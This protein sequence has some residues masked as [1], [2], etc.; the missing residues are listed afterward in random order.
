L[1]LDQAEFDPLAAQQND[2]VGSNVEA[3]G[4]SADVNFHLTADGVDAVNDSVNLFACS[5]GVQS[6]HRTL[7]SAVT[8]LA[9]EW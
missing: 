6:L 7:S 2:A 4:G 3:D 1:R 8:M 5:P 9:P